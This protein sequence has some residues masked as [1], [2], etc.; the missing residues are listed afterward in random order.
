MNETQEHNNNKKSC[1]KKKVSMLGFFLSLF[2]EFEYIAV[3]P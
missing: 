2:G 3:W 1:E